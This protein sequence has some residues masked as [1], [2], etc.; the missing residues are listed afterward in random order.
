MM[1]NAVVMARNL[2]AEIEALLTKHGIVITESNCVDLE[3]RSAETK[4]TITLTK[5]RDDGSILLSVYSGPLTTSNETISLIINREGRSNTNRERVLAKAQKLVQEAQGSLDKKAATSH[6]GELHCREDEVRTA[7]TGDQPGNV[8]EKGP[9]RT[10]DDFTVSLDEERISL[11]PLVAESF[12][13]IDSVYRAAEAKGEPDHGGRLTLDLK[14]HGAGRILSI[15]RGEDSTGA[16][17]Y[18]LHLTNA[19]ISLSMYEITESRG[20]DLVTPLPP[21][22]ALEIVKR[23]A[24]ALQKHL[25]S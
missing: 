3:Y 2:L 13:L 22:Q 6:V 16:V 9:S 25:E 23:V 7:S 8:S 15:I 19:S 12:G 11:R 18:E 10:S 21:V 4:E 17:E 14:I 1:T 5:D 20:A 24:R